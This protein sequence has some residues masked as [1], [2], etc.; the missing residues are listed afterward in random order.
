MSAPAASEHASGS[1]LSQPGSMDD[2]LSPPTT[3]NTKTKRRSRMSVHTLLPPS[4]KSAMSTQSSLLNPN[5]TQETSDRPHQRNK[6]R[7]TRS[8]PETLNGSVYSDS[9]TNVSNPQPLSATGRAHS[10]SVTDADMKRPLPGDFAPQPR[11]DIFGDVMRWKN[12]GAAYS[13]A[14]GSGSVRFGR[15]QMATYSGEGGRPVA[16]IMDPF[17]PQVS[18]DLPSRKPAAGFKFD[19]LVMPVHQLREVQSF[20]SGLTAR[21]GDS[22]QTRARAA[23]SSGSGTEGKLDDMPEGEEA[24]TTP[25]ASFIP[26]I[27]EPEPAVELEPEPDFD[28]DLDSPGLGL[29]PLPE[30]AMHSRYSTDVFDVLQT[31]SGLPLLDRMDDNTVIKISYKPSLESAAP[32]DDPRFV[33]WG[34]TAASADGPDEMGSISQVSR[35]G[36]DL[37]ASTQSSHA[38]RRKSGKSGKASSLSAGGTDVPKVLVSKDEA[39]RRILVAATIERWIAQ[40][41]S[42][43]NYDELLNFFLT[44]RTY[45]SAVDLCH[46]LICRFHWALGKHGSSHDEMV[47]RIVRVRTFVAIRYWLLTFFNVDFLPNRELRLALAGWLNALIRDPILKAHNDGLV[48]HSTFGV[49][50]LAC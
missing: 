45:V 12:G 39:S 42:D 10:H 36:T 7:K 38:S 21:A 2:Y 1:R 26:V 41:T 48:C 31:Y 43:L 27:N 34:E 49:N 22:S 28:L 37:S 19:S 17:G 33:L 13:A 9:T 16:I 5:P 29:Y 4:L 35:A 44:Y 32:R 20:E 50:G 24:E 6:L 25:H 18:F 30:T 23:E 46:L 14:S 40:L 3:S 15:G 8:I 11:G 47:R